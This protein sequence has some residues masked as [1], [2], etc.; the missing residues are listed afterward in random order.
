MVKGKGK[1]GMVDLNS[2]LSFVR[3]GY[4]ER[5]RQTRSY[6][7]KHRRRHKHKAQAYALNK[8]TNRQIAPTL[9]SW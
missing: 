6:N 7:H 2:S 9:G 1:M 4:P 3:P 8:S 5:H